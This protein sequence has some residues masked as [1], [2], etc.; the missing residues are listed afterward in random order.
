MRPP[1]FHTHTLPALAFIL[2]DVFQLYWEVTSTITYGL[3]SHHGHLAKEPD[4]I[5]Y[6]AAS[7][8]QAQ[9]FHALAKDDKKKGTPWALIL[10]DRVRPPWSFEGE[11]LAVDRVP[12][13]R[14]TAI[15]PRGHPLGPGCVVIWQSTR[16]PVWSK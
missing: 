13:D 9:V 14:H 11:I 5:L 3:T 8:E 6:H 15:M 12:S 10:Q 2:E 1:F 16:G 7:W 4:R